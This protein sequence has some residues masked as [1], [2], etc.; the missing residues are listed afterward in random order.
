MIVLI[1]MGLVLSLVMRYALCWQGNRQNYLRFTLM[2]GTLMT[3][4]IGFGQPARL[5]AHELPPI[6]VSLAE[7]CQRVA[8]ACVLRARIS[9]A[10]EEYAN[11][12]P[13]I[14]QGLRLDPASYDLE[15][16][17]LIASYYTQGF[18]PVIQDRF[19]QW[20][21]D[22][23]EDIWVRQVYASALIFSHKNF[24]ALG[25]YKALSDIVPSDHPLQLEISES[26]QIL[27]VK[28]RLTGELFGNTLL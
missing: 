6:S 18:T 5:I 3:L 12:L 10:D 1:S 26:I 27:T 22:H 7:K 13:Y 17:H 15:Q 23:E 14:Q 21:L 9:F 8:G 4:Y 19:I 20:L 25:Q 2:W 24:D 11:A 28:L 16:M